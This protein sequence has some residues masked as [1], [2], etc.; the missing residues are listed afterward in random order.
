MVAW[1]AALIIAATPFYVAD[2]IINDYVKN[3]IVI[4]RDS[5]KIEVIR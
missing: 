4:L 3:D 1:L 5:K 2:G